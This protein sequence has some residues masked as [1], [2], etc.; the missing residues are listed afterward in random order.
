MLW[1]LLSPVRALVWAAGLASCTILG[2]AALAAEPPEP[3]PGADAGAET[4]GILVA[5]DAGLL[6]LDVRGQG[7]QAVRVAL[8]NTS[9][10]RLNV[11]LPPGLVASAGVRQ[12]FQSMGLGV[13]T[14]RTGSFGQFRGGATS[15]G[16]RSIPVADAH[17][18]EAVTVPPGQTVEL[19]VPAVCL[20]FGL[21]TPTSRDAFR[22]MVVEDYSDNPRVR[23]ALR[24]LATLG[25]SQG[26][27]Q[28]V[29]W[30]VCNGVTATQLA[31]LPAKRL[32]SKEIALAARF[33]TVLDDQGTSDRVDPAYLTEGRL[34]V[35]VQVE[36]SLA[37]EAA[38]LAA[39]LDGQRLLGL[40]IRVVTGAEDPI[41]PAP[42]LLLNVALTASGAGQ[43][44]GRVAVWS[45]AEAGSRA[46]LLG[47]PS[48]ERDAAVADLDGTALAQAIDQAVAG[49]F[50]RVQPVRRT[51]GS[52]TLRI[53]NRLPF[54]LSRVVIRAG[55]APRT[56]PVVALEGLG[57][58]PLRS[59]L[60]PIQAAAG[61]I[62]RVECNGL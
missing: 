21:P 11:V 12:G 16:F 51:V 57:I 29:M 28:A 42:A 43:T 6:A 25:T 40:P 48:L 8:H 31:A 49:A 60:V 7:D 54:T 32:N 50:V 52:T 3:T 10:R 14:D 18:Q 37:K 38:R 15:L 17:P 39:E 55:N 36:G 2:G 47:T 61:T 22:L 9:P 56:A 59:T 19:A 44:R 24:S 34:F 58:G 45:A 35:R 4:V 53:E 41:A 1:R 26:V 13:P 30:H 33:V 46:Q 27:A 23:T 5:R 20:N 62:E